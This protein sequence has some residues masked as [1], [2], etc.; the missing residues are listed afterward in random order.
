[1]VLGYGFCIE[2]FFMKNVFVVLVVL[3]SAVGAQAEV[4]GL[5]T[6]AQDIKGERVAMEKRTELKILE[7]LE[8]SRIRDEQNRMRI[9]E[10][11]SATTVPVVA[12]TQPVYS[13]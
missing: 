2:G 9:I 1:M 10:A 13:N 4:S 5:R 11:T 6:R 12:P 8:E 3:A 7:M